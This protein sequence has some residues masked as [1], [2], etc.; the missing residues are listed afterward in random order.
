MMRYLISFLVIVFCITA[1]VADAKVN[2]VE[3]S[4]PA[5]LPA[6]ALQDQNGKD[7]TQDNF[8]GR[9]TLVLMGYTHCPDVCPF[10]LSNLEAVI[11]QT[12]LRVRPDNVPR[13]LFLAVDPKRD[14]PVMRDYIQQFHPDF[15]AA[16]GDWAQVKTL[17]EGLD[18]F[19]RYVK[20]QAEDVYEVQHSAAISVIAPDGRIVA[21]ISPPMEPG[22]TA[23]YLAAM[24]QK[25]R[26]NRKERSQ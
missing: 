15:V 8:K 10:T 6:F 26:R 2:G 13:V 22:A 19:V 14:K 17:V 7:F 21:K 20:K 4:T 1:R 24:Q 23:E 5:A 12:S 11:A 3:L 18:G 9:W 25:Y 16:T